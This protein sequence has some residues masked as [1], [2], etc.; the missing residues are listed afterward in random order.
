MHHDS[1]INDNSVEEL[2]KEDE[3]RSNDGR[4]INL[5]V[6]HANSIFDEAHFKKKN[7]KKNKEKLKPV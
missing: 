7:K 1:N 4:L 5:K 2:P 6:Q 3:E